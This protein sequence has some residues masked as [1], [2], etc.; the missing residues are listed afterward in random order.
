MSVWKQT[1][2]YGV[3]RVLYSRA[4]RTPRELAVLMIVA[5]RTVGNA[6]CVSAYNRPWQAN[7]YVKPYTPFNGVVNN[8]LHGEVRLCHLTR[9]F[10]TPSHIA[11]LCV[12]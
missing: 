7:I 8:N 2:P 12:F 5:K 1:E 4:K 9:L 11:G 6:R 3:V 10:D